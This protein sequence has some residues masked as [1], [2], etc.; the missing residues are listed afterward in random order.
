[1]YA[2]TC[3]DVEC[4]YGV[5]IHDRPDHSFS[6]VA[7]EHTSTGKNQP[8]TAKPGI[9]SPAPIDEA[10][11]EK[12]SYFAFFVFSGIVIAVVVLITV[13]VCVIIRKNRPSYNVFSATDE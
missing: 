11:E 6:M 2:V 13:L 1:M 12:E 7:H 9:P 3:L 5:G 8:P 4:E 10:T